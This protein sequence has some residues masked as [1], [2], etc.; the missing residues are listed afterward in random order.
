MNVLFVV[1][2]GRSGSTLLADVL[3]QMDGVFAAGEVRW[4]FRRGMVEG[5]PCECGRPP[6]G[7]PVWG[8]VTR[9]VAATASPRT[10]LGWQQ[11]VASLSRRVPLLRGTEDTATLG[12]YVPV[13]RRV[14]EALAET[15]GA[16]WIVD[17]SKRPQDLAVAVRAVGREN[18]AAVHLMR[19]PRAVAGSWA[20]AKTQPGRPGGGTAGQRPAKSAFRWAEINLGAELLHRTQPDLRWLHLRYED[21]VSAPRPLLG[22]VADLMGFPRQRLPFT[23]ERTVALGRAHIV[24]GNPDRHREGET[25]ILPAAETRND[26][27]LLPR[28]VVSAMTAL[29]ARR[30]GYPVWG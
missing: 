20:R 5:R 17:T 29:V 2:P 13:V 19:D 7:C 21:L 26:L 15:T 27:P 18:V 1:G 9:E 14:Y 16:T 3:G 8:P 25:E 30:Y 11:E 4:L 23:G 28:A 10:I 24:A 22:Q 12:R 6:T